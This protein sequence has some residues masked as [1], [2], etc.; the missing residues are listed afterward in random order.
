MPT[1]SEPLFTRVLPSV[2]HLRPPAGSLY[3][4][5]ISVEHRSHHTE[6]WENQCTGVDFARLVDGNRSKVTFSLGSRQWQVSLR[7]TKSIAG[8]LNSCRYS[9]YYIDVTG[10]PHHVWAPFLRVF[11]QRSELVYCVYVEPGDYRLSEKPT[12]S[13]IFDLSERIEGV[14]P[15]P[16][17]ASFPRAGYEEALFVPL[18]G[19]EGTRFGHMIEHVQPNRDLI[20]PIIGVPGFRAE[21]PFYSYVGNRSQLEDTG[22]WQNVRFVSAN[23]PFALYYLLMNLSSVSPDRRMIVAM[24]GTKPHAVGAVL[25][26]L[27]SPSDVELV[28]DHPVRKADRTMGTSRVCVYNISLLRTIGPCQGSPNLEMNDGDSRQAT[29]L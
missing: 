17:F 14:S 4:T 8:F 13:T 18:L 24:I 5:G 23:C 7:G 21:Y 15:L 12:E 29:E 2:Q 16:G 1:I 26:Y 20:F 19:F 27:D 22:A 6:Q 11:K 25:F 3:I 9:C 28:Y 10:L